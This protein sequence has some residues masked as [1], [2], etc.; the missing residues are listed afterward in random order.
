MPSKNI[1]N[2]AVFFLTGLVF[3]FSALWAM[4]GFGWAAA[5]IATV[6]FLFVM[7]LLLIER[8]K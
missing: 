6:C 2:A 3:A 1:E 7:L 4:F 8:T 5:F